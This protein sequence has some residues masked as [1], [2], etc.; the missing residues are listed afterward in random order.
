L[1]TLKFADRAKSVMT[2]VKPNEITAFDPDLVKKLMSEINYLKEIL[3]MRKKNGTVKSIEDQF[4]KLK[5]ENEK[6]KQFVMNRDNIEKLIQENNSL[7]LELQKFKSKSNS[8]Q[9]NF[10]TISISN[11]SKCNY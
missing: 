11:Q 6:L 7:K 3:A 1:S 2:K 10:E 8:F 9:N 4:L 5:E